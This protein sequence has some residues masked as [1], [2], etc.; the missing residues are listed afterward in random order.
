MQI[1]ITKCQPIYLTF[2]VEASNTVYRRKPYRN[3]PLSRD[4]YIIQHN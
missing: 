1:K 2:I 3:R 4:S